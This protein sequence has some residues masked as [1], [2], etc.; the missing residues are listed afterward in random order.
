MTKLIKN[1]KIPFFFNRFFILVLGCII[2]AYGVSV[3]KYVNLGTDP[4]ASMIIG[5]AH[6]SSSS[7]GII[8]FILNLSLF[9]LSIIIDKDCMRKIGIGTIVYV[10]IIGLIIDYL[11]LIYPSIIPNN[12]S[13]SLKFLWSLSAFFIFCIGVSLYIK[14]NLG[15]APYELINTAIIQKSKNRFNFKQVRIAQDIFALICGFLLGSTIG[16]NTIILSFF[17]GI[18]THYINNLCDR[19]IVK[20]RW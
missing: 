11:S 15:I 20:N 18:V 2:I 19:Y 1:M 13:F 4:Y 7:Y 16:I 17:T 6:L 9:A 3:F 5:I 12:L 10:T 14:A 8:L